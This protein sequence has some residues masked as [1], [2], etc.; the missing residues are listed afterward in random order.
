M[1]LFLVPKT[2][3]EAKEKAVRHYFRHPEDFEAI[4][5]SQKKTFSG[6]F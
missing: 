5:P 2:K 3:N 1:L 4:L 6:V